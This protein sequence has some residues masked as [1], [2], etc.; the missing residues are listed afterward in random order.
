M[1]WRKYDLMVVRLCITMSYYFILCHK[2]SYFA[3]PLLRWHTQIF[4]L[5]NFHCPLF[6]PSSFFLF[7]KISLFEKRNFKSSLN[8]FGTFWF[9]ITWIC[10]WDSILECSSQLK[11]KFQGWMFSRPLQ[12]LLTWRI[13]ILKLL[14]LYKFYT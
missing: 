13:V 7:K 4:A 8:I 5:F 9:V 14:C 3:P 10:I 6:F 2:F 11:C 1:S 12:R